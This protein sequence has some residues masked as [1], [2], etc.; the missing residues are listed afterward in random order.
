MIDL[1]GVNADQ[2]DLIGAAKLDDGLKTSDPVVLFE[3]Q[4]VAMA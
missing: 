4:Q 3:D 1:V 2:H